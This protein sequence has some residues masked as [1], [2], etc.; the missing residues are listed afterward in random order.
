MS[1][2]RLYLRL[3]GM[4]G[5]ALF[6]SLPS[7]RASS[8]PVASRSGTILDAWCSSLVLSSMQILRDGAFEPITLTDLGLVVQLG[9]RRTSCSRPELW[10]RDFMVVHTNGPHH[11]KI[12][13]CRC[14]L[15]LKGNGNL[16]QLF[17]E[18]WLPVTWRA[19][20][21][22]FTFEVLSSFH[23]INLQSK[24]NLYDYYQTLMRMLDNADLLP[25]T[26]SDRVH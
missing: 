17:R 5:T 16:E 12:A 6:A 20:R 2:R 22:V 3:P 7:S 18:C 21:T 4:S 1:G 13:Y 23:L 9:H 24:T 19:T 26:V 10:S 11:L 25:K 15:H 14:R 8:A